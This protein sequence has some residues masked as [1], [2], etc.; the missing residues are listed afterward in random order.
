[1]LDRHFNPLP[2]ILCFSTTFNL[3]ELI[4]YNTI[5]QSNMKQYTEEDVDSALQAIA[6]GRSLRKAALE[7]GIPR[8][9]LRDR[10]DGTQPRSV[11]FSGLQRL[12]K[13]QED[14]LTQWI[15][16]QEALGLPPTHAQVRTFVSR[17][18]ATK[19]DD[20]ALGKRWLDGFLRRNPVIKTQRS[21]S[22]DSKRVNGATTDIIRLW[23]R[24][25]EI[26]E[27]KAVKPENR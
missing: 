18:L 17:I 10:I 8:T 22:I 12:S 2:S 7:W 3:I 15:L 25:F 19:G 14:H 6:M 23:F 27:V 21:K 11:A 4:F 5:V 9:T 24:R 1:M 26:P 16:T 20:S 13:V